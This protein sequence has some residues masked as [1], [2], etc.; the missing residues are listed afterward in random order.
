MILKDKVAVVTGSGQGIGRAI[1]IALAKEGVKVV[2]NSRGPG[3][4]G[5]DAETTAKEILNMGGQAVPFFGSVSE[6]EVAQKLI[7]TAVEKFGRLDILVN[8]VGAAAPMVAIHESSEEDWNYLIDQCLKSVY[9]CTRAIIEHMIQRGSGKIVN[10]ASTAG[11]MGAS[12]HIAYSSAKAGVIC[13]TKVLAKEVGPLG[14]NVNCVSPGPIATPLL[15][16]MPD[17]I[18]KRKKNLY[19]KRLGKPEE[20]ADMVA[21]LVSEKANFILGQNI[22]V[23]GGVTLGW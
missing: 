4:A 8:N 16:G 5:G 14:I 15:L 22:A 18:E 20:I 19:I 1:A 17:Y 11:M 10:I 21:F 7:Q 6:F 3:T 2:T 9:V 12:I 13:F 23:D